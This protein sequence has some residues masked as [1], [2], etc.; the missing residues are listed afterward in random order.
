MEFADLRE[1]Y[2]GLIRLRKKLPG[3]WDKSAA[4]AER[5]LEK[6]IPRPG[7][8]AFRMDNRLREGQGTQS[9]SAM[10]PENICWK[11]LFIIYN[12]SEDAVRVTLPKGCRTILADGQ[13]TDC[14]KDAETDGE[15]RLCIP[16]C[17]GMILGC[18]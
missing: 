9:G 1:Y 16:A 7:V 3:L 18:P 14:R 5:I 15:G 4:A 17:S 12:A 13:H 11:E 10:I 8:V 6:M 2:K